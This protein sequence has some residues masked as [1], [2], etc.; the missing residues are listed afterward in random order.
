A[1]TL[2]WHPVL[3]L[4]DGKGEAQFNLCDSVTT[5][6]VQAFAHTLD[7]RLGAVTT[8]FVSRLPFTLQ[9]KVPIEVTASDKI[10]I[11]LSVRNATDV[12]R[13][14]KIEVE[15]KGLKQT[16][17]ASTQLDLEADKSVRRLFRFQPSVVEGKASL[18]FKGQSAPFA[19]DNIERTFPVVPDGFPIV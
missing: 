14:V 17:A 15:A 2:Y 1:E 9:P 13:A 7:G 18:L 11:P 5:F 3:V 8:T 6:Q 4:V 10:T 19:E 12:K 16:G